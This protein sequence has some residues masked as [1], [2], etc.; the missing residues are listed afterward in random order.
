MTQTQLK[1][2]LPNIVL[3]RESLINEL[4]ARIPWAKETDKKRISAHRKQ[5]QALVDQFQ[6][7]LNAA[8]KWDYSKLKSQSFKIEIPYR[9]HLGSCPQSRELRINQLVETLNFS[10]QKQFTINPSSDVYMLLTHDDDAPVSM[11]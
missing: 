2:P 1:D 8:L 11:C 6:R 5:E 3:D 10:Q 7:M 4:R 9:Q